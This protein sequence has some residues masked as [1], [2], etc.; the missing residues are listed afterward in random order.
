[1]A[2][3]Q[4]EIGL[5]IGSATGDTDTMWALRGVGSCKAGADVIERNLALRSAQ[6]SRRE[7]FVRTGQKVYFL[8]GMCFYILVDG[9]KRVVGA[10]SQD[11][12][13]PEERFGHFAV[14]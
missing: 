1:M 11:S 9:N 4:R 8:S 7:N 12:I 2:V 5:K 14:L 3:K 6:K 10:A 13:L